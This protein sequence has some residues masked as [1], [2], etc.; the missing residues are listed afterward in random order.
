MLKKSATFIGHRDC[1]SLNPDK[2][3][4]EIEML[5][6]KGVTEFYNGGMGDF[7]WMCARIVFQFKQQY[8]RIKNYLVIPYLTF[9]IRERNYFDD[10]LFPEELESC[11][12]KAAIPRRNRYLVQ[13]AG[14]ALCYVK[15]SWGGAAQTYKLAQKQ[16]LF[17]INLSEQSD[18][19]P[20]VDV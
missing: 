5:I 20:L 18:E 14:Y 3:K 4:A 10:V 1:W 12:F 17:L 2:V 19:D 13:Q 16:G 6:Q 11:H 7:D 8:P 15:Y 9:R